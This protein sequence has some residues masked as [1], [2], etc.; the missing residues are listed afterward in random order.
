[1]SNSKTPDFAVV[2]DELFEAPSGPQPPREF[3]PGAVYLAGFALEI[4]SELLAAITAVKAAAPLRRQQVPGGGLMS[5]AMSNCGVLGWVSDRR[6]YRYSAIDPESGQAWPAMPE[7]MGALATRAAAAAGY[8]GFEPDACL[9][10]AYVPGARMGLHQDRDEQDF[11]APIVSVSLGVPAE[12]LF[13]GATR[14]E[15]PQRLWLRHGDVVVWGGP[16]R[17]NFHGVRPLATARHE[18]TGETRYN[19]TLRKAG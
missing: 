2:Q 10:N 15:R 8:P 12:F 9:I 1:M 14:H 7:C 18:M 16:A 17:L 5:V 19:L 6:G 4:A 13:G 11:G 3:A